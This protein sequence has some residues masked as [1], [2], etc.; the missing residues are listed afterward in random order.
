MSGQLSGST[1]PSGLPGEGPL[2]PNTPGGAPVPTLCQIRG[3]DDLGTHTRYSGCT[4]P[5]ESIQAPP[6]QQG[7]PGASSPTLWVKGLSATSEPITDLTNQGLTGSVAPSVKRDK[8]PAPG[9][10]PGCPCG[11]EKSISPGES[12]A[13]SWEGRGTQ[14]GQSRGRQIGRVLSGDHWEGQVGPLAW[15]SPREAWGQVG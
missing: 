15:G 12:G 8:H 1:W 7:P 13:A 10:T 3:S 4:G 2:G 5:L 9:H 11:P 14:C 6:P